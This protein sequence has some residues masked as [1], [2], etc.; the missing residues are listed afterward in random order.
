MG[1]MATITNVNHITTQR[2]Q[3]QHPQAVV[4]SMPPNMG[5]M[6]YLPNSVN[7]INSPTAQD[8]SNT[9]GH[10]SSWNRQR[11]SLSGFNMH[12]NMVPIY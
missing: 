9:L 8:Q 12:P 1:Q 11:G 3:M 4:P 10:F 7:H 6:P 2:A 5:S